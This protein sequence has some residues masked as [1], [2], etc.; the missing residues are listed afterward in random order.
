VKIW[1]LSHLKDSPGNR[2]TL[3]AAGR[4]GHEITLVDPVRVTLTVSSPPTLMNVLGGGLSGPLPDVVFTRMGSSAP[5]ET[6]LVLRQFELMD[7]LCINSA[8]S[9]QQSRDKIAAFQV[10]AR[11]ELPVP[12]TALLARESD[13]GHV[14][15]NVPGPPWIVKI[16]VSTQG[17]GVVLAESERSLRSICDAFHGVGQRVLVQ[18]FVAEAAGSDIRV[19]VV[20]G[21]A[22]AAMRRQGQKGEFRSNIHRG[23]RAEE[24]KLTSKLSNLAEDAAGALGLE[25]AG[26]DLLESELGPVI[27]EVNGSPGLEALSAA[28]GRDMADDVVRYLEMRHEARRSNER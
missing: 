17:S 27:I 1:L 5:P 19:L 9:L 4:R 13:R 16:P 15:E 2:L 23:G 20:G 24:V 18:A 14:V 22:R 10:L 12:V 3:K 11:S 7:I 8:A 6:L 21:R 26:V 25:V 28:A